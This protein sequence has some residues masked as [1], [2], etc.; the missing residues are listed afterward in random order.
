M[1]IFVQ[2]IV[3]PPDMFWRQMGGH[4]RRVE[5]CS[6]GVTWGIGY[7][8]TPWVYTGGWGGSFLKG[9][10]N[11]GKYVPFVCPVIRQHNFFV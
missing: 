1:T 2:V 7:D 9:N 3:P 10:I 5:T 11:L 6:A 8:N 4:L